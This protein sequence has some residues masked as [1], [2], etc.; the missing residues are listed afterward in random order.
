[1]GICE[2]ISITVQKKMRVCIYVWEAHTRTEN[3]T[4]GLK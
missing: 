3:L 2:A 1:M 4:A